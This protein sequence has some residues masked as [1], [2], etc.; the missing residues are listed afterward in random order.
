MRGLPGSGKSALA[1][2]IAVATGGTVVSADSFFVG[3]DGVYRFDRAQAGAAHERCFARFLA[4]CLGDA[5]AV[6]VDNTNVVRRDW[7]QYAV[8]AGV[9]GYEVQIVAVG[10]TDDAAVARYAARNVHGV[11]EDTIRAM[12]DRWTAEARA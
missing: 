2:M 7:S 3:A 8:A 11:P 6:I 12:R 9:L 1:A 4:A 10:E 5:P